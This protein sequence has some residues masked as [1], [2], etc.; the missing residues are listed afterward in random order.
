MSRDKLLADHR[1]MLG[2][3]EVIDFV[4]EADAARLRSRIDVAV[5]LD[6][7]WTWDYADE[8]GEMRDLYERGKKGQWNAASDIDWSRPFS[9]DEQFFGSDP[10]LLLPFVLAERGADEATCRAAAWDEFSHLC[11]QLL[12]AEQATMQLSGQLTNICPTLHAKFL[13]GLQ[14]IDEVR[15][16]EAMARLVQHKLGTLYPIDPTTKALYDQL[17]GTPSWKAKLLGAQCFLEGLAVHIFNAVAR[18]TTNPLLNDIFSR[19]HVDEARHTAFGYLA[20]RR[21]V[22]EST[23]EEVAEMEEFAFSLAEGFNANQNLAMLRVLGPR[24]GLCPDEVVQTVH[25]SAGWL[26]DNSECFMYTVVPNLTRLGLIT[27]RTE[28]DWRRIGALSGEGAAAQA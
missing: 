27:E 24:Y 13:A 10:P 11:S 6:L 17:A 28:A 9:R 23:P 16:T 7:H 5:P 8:L 14:V 25:A 18:A 21:V 3:F 20:M 12:H 4:D 22:K 15:H 2:D 26:E 1:R 19:L